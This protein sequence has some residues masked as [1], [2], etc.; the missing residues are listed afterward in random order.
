MGFR[1]PFRIQVDDDDVAYVTDYSPDSHGPAAL[2]RPGRHR[3]RGGRAQA[4]Q[5]RLAAVLTRRSCRTTAGTSTPQPLDRDAAGVRVRQPEARPGEHVALEHRPTS[6]QLRPP[7]TSAAGPLVLLPRQ[8]QPAA[9]H[10]VPGVLRRLRRQLPAAVPRARSRRRRPARRGEVRLRR[11]QPEHDEVP[12]VLRRRVR[13]SA[14]SRRTRCARS[15][16]TPTTRLQDQPPARLR[17]RRRATLAFPFECDN[18][19]D[20]QFGPG[21]QLLPAD[22]RRRLLHGQP[23]RRHVPVGVRQGP[24]GAAGRR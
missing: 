3:P 22:L 12:A 8:R 21:R 19:M 1:N 18:P 17:R 4:V 24:A 16:S 20:M 10:A 11:A 7:V 5:L 13:S 15:A 2:P 14:S 23:R 9:R 6:T